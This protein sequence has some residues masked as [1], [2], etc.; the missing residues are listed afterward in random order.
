[1]TGN[2]KSSSPGERD[3]SREA[4][5]KAVILEFRRKDRPVRPRAPA[6]IVQ[7][8]IEGRAPGA[9]ARQA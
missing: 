4:E 8:A 7:R 5:T 3:V 2:V 9:G 1:M 6:G